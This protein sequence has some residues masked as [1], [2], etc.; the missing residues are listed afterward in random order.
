MHAGVIVHD[1]GDRLWAL[2]KRERG[3]GEKAG[4]RWQGRYTFDLVG[5]GGGILLCLSVKVLGMGFLKTYG[6]GHG[7]V[8]RLEPHA[9]VHEVDG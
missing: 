3:R 8:E 9:G 2:D 6:A 4:T 1:P 5:G 7:C